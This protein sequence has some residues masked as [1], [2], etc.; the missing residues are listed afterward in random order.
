[1]RFQHFKTK[2]AKKRNSRRKNVY[3]IKEC[4]KQDPNRVVQA[5]TINEIEFLDHVTHPLIYKPKEL[6]ESADSYHLVFDNVELT[7]LD[8]INGK[9]V[10]NNM[11][12]QQKSQSIL[13]PKDITVLIHLMA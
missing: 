4:L 3:L 6:F 10:T 1:M 2:L 7:L 5:M 13:A 8:M 9:I 11:S 12:A